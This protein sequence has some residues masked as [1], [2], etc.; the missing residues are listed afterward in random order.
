MYDKITID[1]IQFMHPS[2]RDKLE[3]DYLEKNKNLPK[4]VR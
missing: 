3:R 4:G 2:L 1:R